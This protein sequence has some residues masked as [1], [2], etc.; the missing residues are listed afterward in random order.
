[1]SVRNAASELVAVVS[2][3]ADYPPGTIVDVAEGVRIA[4][5]SGSLNDGDTFTVD[6]FASTDTASVLSALGLNTFFEGASAA[7]MRVNP[8]IGNDPSLLA[9]ALDPVAGDNTNARRIADM[10]NQSFDD[11]LDQ[12]M[13]EFA[14]GVAS[15]VAQ[16]LFL[17]DNQRHA[18]ETF[19]SSLR[20]QRDQISG[21]DMDTEAL[22]LLE[23]QRMYEGMAKYLIASDEAMQSLMELIR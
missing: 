10:M 23:F 14:S 13:S 1:M 3:G 11:L 20:Q 12:S 15:R 22:K 7:T 9:A 4:F 6:V 17:R 8:A 19:L 16:V 2:L 21:V 5:S 18:E